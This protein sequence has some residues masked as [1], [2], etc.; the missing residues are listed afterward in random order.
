MGVLDFRRVLQRDAEGRLLRSEGIANV[1]PALRRGV[2]WTGPTV[3]VYDETFRTAHG[4]DAFHSLYRGL[5]ALAAVGAPVLEF[6]RG[7]LGRNIAVSLLTPAAAPESQQAMAVRK[8][9]L[10]HLLWQTRQPQVG[11]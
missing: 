11:R 6:Q 9:P 3:H 10:R 1:E 5:R 2:E 4:L 7:P 8:F